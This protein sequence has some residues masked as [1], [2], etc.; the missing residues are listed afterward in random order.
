M[1][2]KVYEI[3]NECYSLSEIE[4][5]ATPSI[6][7][8]KADEIGC[9]LG[10]D[11]ALF[12][13]SDIKNN[14]LNSLNPPSNYSITLYDSLENAINDIAITDNNYTTGETILYFKVEDNGTCYGSGQL[15]L[16]ISTFPD[17]DSQETIIICDNSFPITITA[18]I[19]INL[20]N[21][22]SYY[23]STNETGYEI[24]AQNAQTITLTIVEN[25]SGCEK[26]KLLKYSVQPL[27]LLLGL[28]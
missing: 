7:V 5:I 13:L 12:N 10:D 22:Y 11:T 15:N 25:V 8:N 18:P 27:L 28:Q 2:A 16:I 24:S 4:L 21:N 26:S 14:I 20:Q 23:W 19:P 17:F 6:V 9:N 3:G 1:I